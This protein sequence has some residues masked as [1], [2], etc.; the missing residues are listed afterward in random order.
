MSII[1]FSGAVDPAPDDPTPTT[2]GAHQARTANVHGI[3]NTAQL[4]RLDAVNRYLA[5]QMFGG[6]PWADITHSKYAGGADPTGAVD[7]TAAIQAA[8]DEMSAGGKRGIV[9]VPPG[10]YKVLGT[11]NCDD[12]PVTFWGPGHRAA[13][14]QGDGTNVIIRHANTVDFTGFRIIGIAFDHSP[15]TALVDCVTIGGAG[16]ASGWEVVNCSF[17]RCRR[18]LNLANARC[19]SVDSSTW[20][21]SGCQVGLYA[22][23]GTNNN[24][25]DGWYDENLAQGMRLND[26]DANI[27][28]GRFQD[29]TTQHIVIE[30]GASRNV[31]TC[32]FVGGTGA[33]Q[34]NAVVRVFSGDHNVFV[35][36]T[37]DTSHVSATIATFDAGTVGN[38]WAWNTEPD[39]AIISGGATAQCV[40]VRVGDAGQVVYNSSGGAIA[41]GIA[42]QSLQHTGTA[43][44]PSVT[45]KADPDTGMWRQAADKLGFATGGVERARLDASATADDTALL[46]YDVTA[47]SVKRVSR[48]AA[49]SGG[50]GFR[51]LRVPN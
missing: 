43:A 22:G 8:V 17:A 23:P 21:G 45:F 36:C 3:A 11:I 46:L 1:P 40:V 7:S 19:G 5:A 48:G 30:G 39:A 51:L 42:G 33:T 4:A 6:G 50:A 37:V 49:D 38:V 29:N 26:A 27:V 16:P 35:G 10:L 15:T 41:E 18:G 32:T 28:R 2:D 34:T 20:F 14:F 24:E 25:F 13:N 31:F 47:G 9:W 12:K 44:A